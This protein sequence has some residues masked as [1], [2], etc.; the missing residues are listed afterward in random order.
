MNLPAEQ[1][2][3]FR[4]AV[5]R[6]AAYQL[7]PP[8]HRARAH[9][10]ALQILEGLPGMASPAFALELA[11]HAE[12]ALPGASD[13]EAHGLRSKL[14]QYLA[15]G[16][17]YARFNYDYAAGEA[18]L[19]KLMPLLEGNAE[20]RMKAADVMADLCQ[21]MGRHTEARKWFEF[22]I[23]HGTSPMFRGRALLHLAWEALEH[24][25]FSRA[26][27]LATRGEP[28]N[29]LEPDPRMTVA[30]VLYHAR[31]HALRGDQHEANRLQNQALAQAERGGDW[32]QAV[33]S[34][35]HLAEGLA[36]QG[37]FEEA[38]GHLDRAEPLVQGPTAANWRAQVDLGRAELLRMQGR[39][40][41]ALACLRNV[42]EF[43]RA[44]GSMGMYASALLRRARILH[45]QGQVQQ[46]RRDAEQARDIATEIGD[47]AV[48]REAVSVA[49]L[50]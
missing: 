29:E 33:I 25:D 13:D 3:L 41:D 43:A 28:L 40:D 19:R 18:A 24:G 32:V 45:E 6:Q 46:A 47:E 36:K 15:T 38:N 23:E 5:V 27:G 44:T 8:L 14:T 20:R 11:G 21:R 17:D 16:A 37:N 42:T 35:L 30:W 49:N 34:H 31:R 2:Y 48:R 26:E 1:V 7:Q 4:H 12:N 22:V 39:N 9:A 50:N 10:L